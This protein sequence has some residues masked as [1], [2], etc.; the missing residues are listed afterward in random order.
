M[1]RF[2]LL[3]LFLLSLNSFGQTPKNI[4]ELSQKI[5][6]SFA[7]VS[8]DFAL[9]FRS[10]D[11]PRKK[12]LINSH[13]EF[14]AASTMKTP[15][16]IEVFKQAEEGKLSLDDSLEVKNSFKSIV[17]GSSF[18]LDIDR[19]GG[20]QLYDF[21]G[22]KKSLR[23][24]VTD[25][26]IYSS[27]LATNIVIQKVD[28]KKVNAT[29]HKM[30]AKDINVLRGV[31][32]MKAYDAG[33]SNSTTA[34]DLMIIFEHL[35]KGKAVNEKADRQ[36]IDI[37]LHQKHREIIPAL[38][39]KN[40]EVA[41]KTGMITGVHHDSG[42]VFL[43]DGRKYILVILSKNMEDMEKGTQMMARISKM[44]YDFMQQS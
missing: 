5:D 31:E 25:M 44:I 28:A 32:D 7:S 41:N 21:L 26:I 19:D 8:G 40:V 12:L 35:A 29:M 17:D 6:S 36:M 10:L 4:Q 38:L 11:Y 3:P 14:H 9:A 1:K 27:N 2:L 23:D 16:M 39:P 37:L 13:G 42:I 24:L 43:P 20:E 30:G 33:L 18:S 22:K 15:V 34:Y